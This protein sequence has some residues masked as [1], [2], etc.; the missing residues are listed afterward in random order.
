MSSSTKPPS[1]G[2]TLRSVPERRYDPVSGTW[3]VIAADRASRP[4]D[5]R[6]A[7]DSPELESCAFCAGR[8]D[9]TTPAVATWAPLSG[10]S[11]EA[12]QVRIVPNL[13]PAFIDPSETLPLEFA[14][15]ESSE[16][17]QPS[18]GYHDVV[19][20]SPRHVRRL[21]DLS[22]EE[23]HLVFQAYRERLRQ[24]ATDPEI[25]VG[26]IFKNC[27]SS[28]GMSREH[29]HSQMVGLPFVPTTL[30]TELDRSQA[31][32]SKFG[33]CLFCDLIQQEREQGERVVEETE[34]LIAYCP[35]ASRFAFEIWILPKKHLFS[36][37]DL[38]ND[39]LS[40]LSE[41]MQRLLGKLEK[42]LGEPSYNYLIHTS[43]FDSHR[44]DHYH[45]HIEIIPRL[46]QLAG[47]ELGSGIHIN[48]VPPEA[49]AALLRQNINR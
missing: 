43:P 27:G 30:Q 40:E 37:E 21:T 34:Q 5:I 8:E 18:R 16:S 41:L 20:E 15:S 45:W 47:L 14:E 7:A 35:F 12:W 49:A 22:Q 17:G 28:A 25:K 29:I 46:S 9:E 6:T 38:A 10:S 48:S 13:Y 26:L 31:H 23:C 33:T 4:H 11:G 19:I 39:S 32:F 44:K 36:F 3:V 42:Q 24:Y 1:I 2:P